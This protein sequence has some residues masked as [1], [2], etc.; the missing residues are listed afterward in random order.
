MLF[1]RFSL[2]SALL[3]AAFAHAGSVLFTATF[4]PTLNLHAIRA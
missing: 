4:T 2:V 1:R 3:V